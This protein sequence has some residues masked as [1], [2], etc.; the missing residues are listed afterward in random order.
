[1]C[2]LEITEESPRA[3]ATIHAKSLPRNVA[4]LGCSKEKHSVCHFFDRAGLGRGECALQAGGYDTKNGCDVDDAP[5]FL[6]HHD[7]G[8]RPADE[9][10]SSQINLHDPV[11]LLQ[12]ELVDVDP[13]L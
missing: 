12:R 2:R 1:M 5:V 9:K 10:R 7:A 4:A 6:L 11:P 13:M 8:C 3:P